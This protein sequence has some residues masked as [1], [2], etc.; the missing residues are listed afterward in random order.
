M[1]DFMQ[2]RTF[3][4]QSALATGAVL[5]GTSC[6]PKKPVHDGPAIGLQLYT[7]RDEVAKGIVPIIEKI[8]A[9]GYTHLETYGYDKGMFFGK[10]P[11]EFRNLLFE[12]KLNTPSGHYYADEFVTGNDDAWKKACEA[13]NTLEQEY[14]ILPW[15]AENLRPKDEAGFK[16][17]CERLNALGKISKEA[18]LQFAYHN[19]DFELK[20]NA[21][22]KT[23]LF[24][25][26]M[27]DTDPEL[28]KLEMDIFW[29]VFAEGDPVTLFY[30]YPKRFPLWHVKDLDP[31]TRTNS[32]L[33]K[34]IIDFP[35]IFRH[36]KEAGLKYYFVEQENYAVSPLDSIEK[37][38]AYVK[39]AIVA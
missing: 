5:T 9:L 22:A 39:K 2:R 29:V 25:V 36:K 11:K 7:V 32:D 6:S 31:L 23:S 28:V 17:F 38:I 3:L 24:Q 15:M 4:A 26:I 27:T 34:G 33:G 20:Y 1:K 21:Q 37:N 30:Q 18:G 10:T 35:A 16:K 19:H 12:N 14:I 13:A 8:G